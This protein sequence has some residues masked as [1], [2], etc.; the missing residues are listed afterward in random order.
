MNI[1]IVLVSATDSLPMTKV[2]AIAGQDNSMMATASVV[3][4]RDSCKMMTV[5]CCYSCD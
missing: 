1:V 3:A 4:K 5:Q 2:F